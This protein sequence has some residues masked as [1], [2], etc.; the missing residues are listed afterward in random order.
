MDNEVQSVLEFLLSN[1]VYLVPVLAVA[2]MLMYSLLKKLIKLA[3]VVA[4]AGGMYVMMLRY[5]GM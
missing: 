2:A 3:A 4:I 5:L 1:P